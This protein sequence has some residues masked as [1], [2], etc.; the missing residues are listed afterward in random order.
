MLGRS[1]LFGLAL[2]WVAHRLVRDH[3]R[4]KRQ[5]EL[6]REWPF[7]IE[8]MAVAAL[9]GM[10]PGD[11]FQAAAQRAR[12]PMREETEKV[13][14]RLAGGASLSR[15]LSAMEGCGLPEVRRLR[16]LVSQ[17]EIL[18]TP[19]ADM[20]KQLSDE[21]YAEERRAMEERF[22]ALPIKLSA[23]TVFFL[24]PPVLAVSVMPHILAFIEAGW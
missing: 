2:A 14:L 4:L 7:L 11:A 20:L 6:R 8:S 15:A 16:A 13:V 5:Q 24:L 18:G 1:G 21:G 3:R 12:G 23:I 22:N 10:G 9:S 19:V 17:C